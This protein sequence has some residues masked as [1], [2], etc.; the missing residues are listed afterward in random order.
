MKVL[1][2]M[3]CF[4]ANALIQALFGLKLGAIPAV[5]FFG[6]T[7]SIARNFAS[8]YDNRKSKASQ[9]YAE[10]TK[11][12]MKGFVWYGASILCVV[13]GT[14][15]NSADPISFDF[16][17]Q[18]LITAF[19]IGLAIMGQILIDKRVKISYPEELQANEAKSDDVIKF[20]RKCGTHIEKDS[21]FC[22]KCGTEIKEE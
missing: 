7:F 22:R 14:I 5:M 6:S 9:K 8:R 15:F 21:R 1:I 20:C 18:L 19:C 3:G 16:G 12:L 10:N 2:W 4:L 17:T 11:G 13:L